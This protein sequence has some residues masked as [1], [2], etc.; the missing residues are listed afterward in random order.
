MLTKKDLEH[1]ADLSRMRLEESKE[2]KLLHDLGGIL[3]HFEELK[4]LNTD[5][6]LPLNGGTSLVNAWREDDPGAAK[7]DGD[8]AKK[9]F[10]E[11]ENGYLKV[12][13]VFE[14]HES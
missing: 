4:E 10:P 12:P 1:L 2:E 11:T 14:D 13:A 9:E 6:V 7:L 5:N 3:D 8:P